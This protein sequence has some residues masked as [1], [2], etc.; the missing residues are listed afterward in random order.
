M[1]LIKITIIVSKELSQILVDDLY[2]LGIRQIFVE[3]GR[4]SILEKS[5]GISHF[6]KRPSISTYPVEIISLFV[7]EDDE[8]SLLSYVARKYD[9][10]TSGKGSIYSQKIKIPH[11]HPDYI[12]KQ[13]IHLKVDK[14]E[15]FFHQL[16][17]IGCIVQ[18][19]EG[20]KISKI[21]LNYGASVPATTHGEG[22]GARN[23]LGLLRITI[24]PEKELINL[25]LSKHDAEAVMELYISEGKLDEPG[26]GLAYLYPIRQG[27]VNTKI[28]RSSSN[29]AA[30]IE[31]MISAI[32]SIKGGMEWRK[33]RLE[34]E[35]NKRRE[36][37]S[38]LTEMNL[39]CE[40]G[41]GTALTEAAMSSGAPG[42]TICKIRSVRQ[43]DDLERIRIIREVC[44]MI[45]PTATVDGITNA[46]K[47]KGCF[48]NE[49]KAMLYTLPVQKAF[50]YRA[51]EIREN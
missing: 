42:A 21:A 40:E 38:Q 25:T 11:A 29:Q 4:T 31:Q 19:G 10:K 36:F 20:D 15:N 51:K 14:G 9:L 46:L 26:R 22:S 37:L 35:S 8:L 2:A 23:K 1:K 41:R 27:L 24:P 6:F 3:L 34:H 47:D 5:N 12:I 18:R 39:I 44:K 7:H 45:V 17:G 28:S 16:M 50:T 13:D 33:S 48:V 30:S 32:D 49:D 43:G